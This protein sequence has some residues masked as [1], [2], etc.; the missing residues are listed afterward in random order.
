[1][2]VKKTVVET[3]N[4]EGTLTN[5]ELLGAHDSFCIL[6]VN[7]GLNGTRAYLD[8]YYPNA[9]EDDRRKK[10][11]GAA[12]SAHNLLKNPN[13]KD[14]IRFLKNQKIKAREDVLLG[15]SEISD[16]SVRPFLNYGSDGSQFPFFDLQSEEAKAALHLV[17]DIKIKRTRRWE[18]K[19]EDAEEWEDEEVELKMY[20]RHEALKDMGRFHK[21]F[22]DRVEHSGT[23]VEI[24]WNDLTPQQL[25]RIRAGEDPAVIKKEIDDAKAKNG[26]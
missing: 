24:P 7:Y 11:P 21:L 15:L 1:M 3:E 17:K 13:I 14:R 6:Y 2:P 25:A 23:V 5:V 20:N 8:V 12:V 10:Y 9:S 22:V 19:G 18:G 16:S 26:K 4:E